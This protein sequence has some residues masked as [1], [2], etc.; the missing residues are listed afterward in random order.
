[1]PLLGRRCQENTGKSRLVRHARA[2]LPQRRNFEGWL[3]AVGHAPLDSFP[4]GGAISGV[5]TPENARH[6]PG[7]FDGSKTNTRR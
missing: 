4:T 6:A 3:M 2:A 1:M 5:G 7:I